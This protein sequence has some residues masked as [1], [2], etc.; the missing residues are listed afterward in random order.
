[1]L[2]PF[3]VDFAVLSISFFDL[4]APFNSIIILIVSPLIVYRRIPSRSL[5]SLKS[6]SQS[7][8]DAGIARISRAAVHT[9]PSN[10]SQKPIIYQLI[11]MNIGVIG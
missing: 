8:S 10:I 11:L 5:P 2:R 1:V 7:T 6:L 3:V 9:I 4:N